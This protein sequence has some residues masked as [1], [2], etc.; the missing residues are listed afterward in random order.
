M[1]S[2]LLCQATCSEMVG[3]PPPPQPQAAG[4]PLVALTAWQALLQA[5]PQAGQRVLINAASGGVG[6]VAVQ[7]S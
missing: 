4:M 5:K 1:K 3:M 7:A 2:S 6:H